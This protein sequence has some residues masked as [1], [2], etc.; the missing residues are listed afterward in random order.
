MNSYI[1]SHIFM[2]KFV[3]GVRQNLSKNLAMITLE[4]EVNQGFNCFIPKFELETTA[5]PLSVEHIVSDSNNYF[6]NWNNSNF[7]IF[8]PQITDIIAQ[9]IEI[10]NYDLAID[11]IFDEI[12]IYSNIMA[13]YFSET[14]ESK[15][16]IP[17]LLEK[18]MDNDYIEKEEWLR[19][20]N[21][22]LLFDGI[23]NEL[24][25]EGP[26]DINIKEYLNEYSSIIVEILLRNKTYIEHILESSYNIINIRESHKM[27]TIQSCKFVENNNVSVNESSIAF[28][29]V[30]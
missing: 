14:I 24:K 15:F 5:N 13:K 25:D 29:G 16:D 4:R 23:K 12:D 28:L 19:L 7:G 3:K 26:Y 18:L 27:S 1:L 30:V 2:Y 6:Y 20:N 9:M 8:I 22:L 21:L 17:I 11:I 10:K